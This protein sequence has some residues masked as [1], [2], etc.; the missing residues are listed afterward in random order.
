MRRMGLSLFVAA[1]LV[2]AACGSS[3]TVASPTTPAAPT[4]TSSTLPR[5]TTTT[6]PTTLAPTTTTAPDPDVV[7]AVITPAYVNAVFAVL[8]H[9]YGNAVRLMVATH[10]IPV[11]ATVELRAIFADPEYATEL[12]IFSF[13]LHQNP[14]GLKHPPGDEVTRV[15]R[16]LSSSTSCIYIQTSTDYSAVV[17][18]PQRAT[19][20]EFYG[21]ELKPNSIDPHHLNDSKWAIFF[22]E[23]FRS[24]NPP[25]ADPCS[26]TH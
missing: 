4:T 13:E 12:K 25:P 15:I 18:K 17:V 5:P 3:H 11:Q 1:G 23:S 24:S 21:L 7:P 16:I 9:V 20:P 10:K 26:S 22:N 19:G 2:L 6:T 14:Q 8:N